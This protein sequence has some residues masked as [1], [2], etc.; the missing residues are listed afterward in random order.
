MEAGADGVEIH[1]ANGY[2]V[3]QFL[4]SNA[5]Q[6]SDRYGGS[7]DNRVRFGV[8]VASAVV[9]AVGA[10]RV[11][12]RIS[13][14]NTYNDIKEDDAQALYQALLA[15]LAPLGLA[16]LHLVHP[17]DEAWARSFRDQWPGALILNRP[18]APFEAR[19]ADVDAGLADV[20]SVGQL[21]L[22]NPDLVKRLKSGAPLNPPDPSTY[23]GGDAKGYTDYPALA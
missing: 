11:G 14:G 12:F 22:A 18:G 23:F 8:E 6:R 21:A 9:K 17:K 7:I 3:Q 10:H 16:Y 19:S 2:L 1:G 15:G 20:A 13:P 4:S 5:N